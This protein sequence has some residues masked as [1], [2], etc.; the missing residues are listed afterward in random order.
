MLFLTKIFLVI[1]MQQI[2][3]LNCNIKSQ[4]AG[5]EIVYLLTDRQVYFS[6]ESIENRSTSQLE[7]QFNHKFNLYK[8][9]IIERPILILTYNFT[10]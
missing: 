10:L 8:M 3:F 9:F 2:A 7:P 1:L 6:G 5:S 4:A